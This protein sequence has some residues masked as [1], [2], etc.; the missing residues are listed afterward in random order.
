MS[1]F[2][3]GDESAFFTWL[4]S[5]PGVVSVRGL[6]RELH[7]QTRST[8]L[9]RTSIIE[10]VAIYRRYNGNLSELAMFITESNREW[11]EPMLKPSLPKR[12]R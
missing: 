3:P 2:A 9:S 8:R 12:S 6:G 5:I 1:Y 10:L 7:I 4:Q 11:L